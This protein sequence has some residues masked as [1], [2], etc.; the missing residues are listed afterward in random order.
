M[1]EYLSESGVVSLSEEEIQ[2]LANAN[3]QTI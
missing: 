2:E 3:A 1:G